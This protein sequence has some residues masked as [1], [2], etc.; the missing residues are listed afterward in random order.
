MFI[1]AH[2]ELYRLLHCEEHVAF[3]CHIKCVVISELFNQEHLG[4]EILDTRLYDDVHEYRE[5][6]IGSQVQLFCFDLHTIPEL[7]YVPID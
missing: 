4:F 6:L 5:V 3:L 7:L 1:D 2:E